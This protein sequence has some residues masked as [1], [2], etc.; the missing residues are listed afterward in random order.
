TW[1]PAASAAAA[2][3]SP[4]APMTASTGAR[5]RRAAPDQ[6][7]SRAIDGCSPSSTDPTSPSTASPHS[8]ASTAP[9]LSSHVAWR[10]GSRRARTGA[11]SPKP[12]ATSSGRATRV[13]APHPSRASLAL[14][15]ARVAQQLGQQPLVLR[16]QRVDEVGED[17]AAVL[18]VV[19][20]LAHARGGD[21]RLV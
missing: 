13:T 1:S 17:G 14:A 6:W 12:A 21:A 20:H 11:Q 9:A 4:A 8:A 15:A 7:P 18:S 3:A 19:E 5:A 2:A 16:G 10:G